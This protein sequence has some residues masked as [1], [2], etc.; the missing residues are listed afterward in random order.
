[1]WMKEITNEKG[2]RY[3]YRERFTVPTTGKI[4]C[5]SVTLNSNTRHAERVA[6]EMLR[7]K[8]KKKTET[9]TERKHK[10]LET[11][12]LKDVCDGWQAFTAPTVKEETRDNHDMYCRR[13]LWGSTSE[14]LFVE[15]T[16]V[17]AEKIV[18]DMYYH[19]MLSYAY[20]SGTLV[21]IKAIMRYAKK[22]GYI[23]NVSDYEDIKLKRRPATPAEL[24]KTT[25]KF[26]N[27]DELASCLEQL[28]RVSIRLAM[29][30]E[31]ISLT[32]LRCGEMLA[33]RW[34]DYNKKA[35]TISVNGTIVKIA[36]NG[37]VIQ[38]G[39]PKNIYSFRT[40]DLNARAVAIL[41][42]FKADNAR[43]AL[44]GHKGN[45]VS[46]SYVDR[47]YI[48]TTR[49]G[50]PYNIQYINKKLRGIAI[51]GKKISTHIFRHTH[52]SML[53]ELNVPLKAIMQRVGHNDPN[54][55]LSIYTHVTDTMKRDMLE[56][57]ETLTV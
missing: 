24:E 18:S 54:T 57:L 33:L 10:I 17:L 40:V 26:L 36:H 6:G 20:C 8:F 9:A 7:E 50:Y 55:T 15:F 42:W 48:F 47:G 1:M 39:T 29:A 23:G 35:Q 11:L 44:W 37:D 25:N 4:I 31:F 2:T 41:A 21:T 13:I 43:L 3:Q 30:M 22:A 27:K 34:Q 46:R 28:K 14:L 19:E 56:K 52:I 32:G 51:P 53:A 12:T 49:Y 16:P 38:R 5:L 45:C